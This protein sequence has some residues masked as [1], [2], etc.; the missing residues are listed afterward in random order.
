METNGA[1]PLD[2]VSD[3]N[4]CSCLRLAATVHRNKSIDPL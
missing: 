2:P 1:V 3:A 4:L